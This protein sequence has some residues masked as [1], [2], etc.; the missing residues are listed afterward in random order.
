M[1]KSKD[2]LFAPLAVAALLAA[3]APLP[4]Q[5]PPAVV[6]FDSAWKIINDT[7]F[8]TTFNGVDWRRVRDELRP[9][10]EAATTNDQ[11]RAVLTE[12]LQRLKQSHFSII[13]QQLAEDAPTGGAGDLGL[14]VRWVQNA[15]VVTR[16]D[17]GSPAADAGIKT[18]WIIRQVGEHTVDSM[19][20]RA[21]R[22]PSHRSMEAVTASI[23]KARMSG[24][25]GSNVELKLLDAGN[26][27]VTRVLT[28]RQDAG[29]PLK[30][31]NLPTFYSR[32]DARQLM[33]EGVR[34]GLISFNVWMT[35][36]TVRIDSAVD[37]YRTTQGFI[38]DLRGNPGGVGFMSTGVAGHFV[39][40]ANVLGTMS[41]RGSRLEFRI[42]PRR[43]SINGERVVPFSGP[44]AILT[45]ELSGST[46]E[47]FAGGMQTIGR[48]RVFGSRS[49][50][51][52]LPAAMN[53][54]PSGDVLYHAIADFV[55][56]GG[57]LLEGRGVVP[58]EQVE[59]KRADLLAGRD[60]V[61][62]AAQRWIAAQARAQRRTTTT[63][64][65][66]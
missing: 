60:P 27:T 33:H 41:S 63:E 4:A 61:L 54:L 7:H 1:K 42:N 8:D 24:A 64:N 31:G 11:L 43:V 3:A 53:K 10:A 37:R 34:I 13:P 12:M 29:T 25:P 28:R 36:L 39:D 14:D 32:F 51:A 20:A 38:I 6:T 45:D 19:V 30:L 16:V 44:V 57:T 21:R 35:P 62:D 58:D 55:L 56:P 65:K 23:A 59:V 5:T 9:K 52:V 18:G 26:R 17:A 15:I 50:G 2:A 48:V 47:V 49:M 46:S 40:T 22:D 66:Q